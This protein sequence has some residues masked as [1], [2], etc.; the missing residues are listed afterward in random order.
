MAAEV[1]PDALRT[2]GEAERL[3]RKL[4]NL[5]E[6]RIE[7]EIDKRGKS[8]EDNNSMVNSAKCC[9]KRSV[10]RCLPVLTLKDWQTAILLSLV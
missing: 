3:M 8:A 6:L 1:S 7:G 10:R 4:E 9:A 5:K 2:L